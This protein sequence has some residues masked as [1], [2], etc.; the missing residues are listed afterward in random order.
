MWDEDEIYESLS[1]SENPDIPEPE[2]NLKFVCLSNS[3]VVAKIDSEIEKILEM[4]EA[5]GDPILF[6]PSNSQ[7]NVTYPQYGIIHAGLVEALLARRQWQ[8]D[9]VVED[10]CHSS[11]KLLSEAGFKLDKLIAGREW[12]HAIQSN[13]PLENTFTCPIIAGE[14]EIKSSITL[15]C[16]HRYSEEAW[17][18]YLESQLDQGRVIGVKCMGC[19]EVVPPVMI[20]DLLDSL[21]FK[22]LDRRVDAYVSCSGI[23]R[24]C[25]GQDC[26]RKLMSLTE[27]FEISEQ[28]SMSRECECNCGTSFCFNCGEEVHFPI[29]CEIIKSWNQKNQGEAENVTWI[30][31]HTKM[32]PNCKQP[33]EKNQGCMHMTCRCKHEFC[34]LCMA[35][36]RGHSGT[37]YYRCNVY[38]EKEKEEGTDP[39]E[40]ERQQAEQSLE[41][42]THFY[43]RYRAH[44]QGQKFALEKLRTVLNDF[45]KNRTTSTSASNH[46]S[47]TSTQ[48]EFAIHA[49]DMDARFIEKMKNAIYKI[50][51]GRRILKF[52]Y[53]FGYYA[54]WKDSPQTKAL[55][56]HQ[57]G[58]LEWTLDALQGLTELLDFSNCTLPRNKD[59]LEYNRDLVD[60]T[61]VVADFFKKMTAAFRE[62]IVPV[63]CPKS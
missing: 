21:F 6:Q 50:I 12:Q 62:E 28:Y 39:A 61:R 54:D 44:Q 25:P 37:G 1:D 45:E 7:A 15:G 20:E 52:S 42:Y 26:N 2:N 58:E 23:L 9:V 13:P 10:F 49:E 17:I 24:N 51:E 27:E 40:L 59:W 11:T 29:P 46:L 19:D 22:W 56:E 35:P 30:F 57:Q 5:L 18:K 3:D 36:W 47:P 16:G 34:W 38:E 41:R 53:A 33:I 63:G 55:Y 60:R 31:V 43:E 48:N 14:F 4:L 8:S 32:C